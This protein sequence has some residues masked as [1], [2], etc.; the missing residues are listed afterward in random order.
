MGSYQLT[1]DHPV[2]RDGA[3][4]LVDSD[5]NAYEPSDSL[6]IPGI[7][8]RACDPA[9]WEQRRS[10]QDPELVARFVAAEVRT[11]VLVPYSP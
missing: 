6:E 7:T 3:P 10:D 1:A 5:G 2:S 8:V 4:V 11:S 9:R